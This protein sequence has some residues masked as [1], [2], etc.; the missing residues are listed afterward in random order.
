MVDDLDRCG[1]EGIVKVFE[2]I[3]LVLDLKQVIVI[4][5]VDHNV[6]MAALA[7]HY[8]KLSKHHYSRN[9]KIIARDYLAK[10]IH[11]PIVLSSPDS[12]SLSA[13]LDYLWYENDESEKK[14][15]EPTDDSKESDDSDPLALTISN[16]DD[17]GMAVKAE[18]NKKEESE[19]QG[20][21]DPVEN[22]HRDILE[23]ERPSDVEPQSSVKEIKGLSPNQKEA[24]KMWLV[25]F[26][27]SNPRQV[28]RLNQSHQLLR[29]Y[30]TEDEAVKIPGYSK[31]K[32]Y[33][34]VY[35]MMV[36]LFALEYI[37]QL[38]DASER[39]RLKE[40][41]KN[42]EENTSDKVIDKWLVKIANQK[43]VPKG[44]PMVK[45]IEPF[46]LPSIDLDDADDKADEEK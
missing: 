19:K 4:I 36:T 28:K 41:L 32:K 38:E 35:P 8:D 17:A 24:F 5:A 26:N 16:Q 40:C 37:N 22:L 42:N 29:L 1:H 11:L 21:R 45:E 39:R 6:A 15:V 7:L 33:K 34:L 18:E 27:L 23:E 14:G 3:R 30:F 43:L 13:Y 2:A 12:D 31:N 20:L 9:A 44:V 10:I 25:Y 46:V